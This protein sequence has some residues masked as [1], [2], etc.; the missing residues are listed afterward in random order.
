MEEGKEGV[1]PGLSYSGFHIGGPLIRTQ[2]Y[3]NSKFLM[4]EFIVKS[5]KEMLKR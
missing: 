3:L 5:K 1:K 4:A 2:I